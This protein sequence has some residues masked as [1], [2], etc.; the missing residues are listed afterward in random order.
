MTDPDPPLA[1]RLARARRE[2]I[3]LIGLVED[4]DLNRSLNPEFS[5]MRWHL[6]HV[7]AYE[8]HWTLVRAGKRPGLSAE[9]DHL[10]DPTRNPKAERIHLPPLSELLAFAARVRDETLEV[11]AT[12]SPDH[13]DPLLRD[14][15][16]GELVYE[17]ECQHREILAFLLQMIPPDRKRR[18]DG[19]APSGAGVEPPDEMVSVPEGSFVMGASG[20]GFAYDNEKA[21]HS[22]TLPAYRMARSPV[23]ESAFARFIE[24]GGYR[25]EALWSP[26]GWRW[27]R[28]HEVAAPR[29]WT[30]TEAGGWRVRTQ[31]EDRDPAPG[32]PVI[33]VSHFEA[34]AYARW[35][36]RR[37]PTE[38]EWERA[39]AWDAKAGR[40]R[41]FPWGDAL[42]T[43][44]LANTDGLA[45]GTRPAS[46][47]GRSAAG[48]DELAGQV[49]EWTASIF[50]P[51][52]GFEP[53]PYAG[54]SQAWFDGE[55]FVLRGGSWATR[56]ELCRSSFRNW[57][58]PHVREMFAGFR[59]AAD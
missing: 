52:S 45:W 6:G 46:T 37:L 2:T 39:A 56:G 34:S 11:L 27:V 32:V 7:A 20:R 24:A 25:V 44:E 40:A 33:G 48:C 9:Y 19:F 10:F 13:P 29:D 35:L 14:G 5:P 21:A 49:W 3:A 38:A 17:H 54:Y 31:F 1:D 18:P 12:G 22:V 36:G 55:H 50:A 53:F 41:R 51:Y 23:T 59:C 15:F 30:A 8:A 42:P 16:V 4:A 26:E 43:A 57:Y 28:E 47:A 58:H